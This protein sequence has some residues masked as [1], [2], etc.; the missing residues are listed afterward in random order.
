MGEKKPRFAAVIFGDAPGG[1]GAA[2]RRFG[3]PAEG[4]G[5]EQRIASLT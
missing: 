3:S 4:R 5:L 2:R 1:T